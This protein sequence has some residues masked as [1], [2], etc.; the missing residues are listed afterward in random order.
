[1]LMKFLVF[2]YKIVN[3]GTKLILFN[4][5]NKDHIKFLIY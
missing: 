3:I 1:M 5:Y 4:E 2:F